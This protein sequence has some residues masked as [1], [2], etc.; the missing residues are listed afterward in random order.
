MTEQVRF[1]ESLQVKKYETRQIMGEKAAGDVAGAIVSLLKEREEISMIFA[2]ALSQNE[3]L[4]SLLTH[5]EIDF[6]RINAFHMD[7]YVGLDS[8]APQGFGNFLRNAIFSRAP[9]KSI[10]YINGQAENPEEECL[11]YA[12]LISAAHIDIVCM[13][14]GEN[15]H[16]AFNDPGEADFED[17]KAVKLVRLDEACRNQQVHDGCF[18]SL[19]QVPTTAITLTVPTLTK[20]EYLFCMVPAKS[21]AVAVKNSLEKEISETYPASI[22]RK[23]PGSVLY[24]DR[25]SSSLLDWPES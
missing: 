25:E 19:E 6:S 24:L 2:A 10:Q 11:R 15:A 9:F 14:I 3:F 4:H 20:G 16:I 22:L 7:E 18:A 8:E 23:V 21:K 5:K 12:A 17:P 13:G 1:Y